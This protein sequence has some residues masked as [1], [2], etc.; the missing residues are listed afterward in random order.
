[1]A[2]IFHRFRGRIRWVYANQWREI[3]AKRNK[4]EKNGMELLSVGMRGCLLVLHLHGSWPPVR[5]SLS[6][7]IEKLF[8]CS[9]FFYGFFLEC[10]TFACANR[11]LLFNS[12]ILP[13]TLTYEN[14]ACKFI[15][16]SN[17]IMV[18]SR[19]FP[20]FATWNYWW[21]VFQL[22]ENMH[23]CPIIIEKTLVRMVKK[24]TRTLVAST[25]WRYNQISHVQWLHTRPQTLMGRKNSCLFTIT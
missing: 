22:I 25:P 4:E 20:Y 13:T 2:F 21:K 7:R 3:D 19:Q 9:W 8:Q 12:I 16:S 10:I 24:R 23:A 15:S 1:M 14:L 18:D 17:P 11:R 5:W 6:N